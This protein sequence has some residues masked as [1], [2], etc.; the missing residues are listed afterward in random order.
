MDRETEQIEVRLL[1]E[2]IHAKYGYDLRDYSAASM[3]RRVMAA[4]AKAGAPHLGELQH[5]L[6]ADRGFFASVLDDLMVQVSEMF[7]DPPFFR[8]FRSQVVPVLQ[9]Y[10]QLKIWHAGC[11]SGEEVYA[12]AILLSEAGLYD[13]TQIYATDVS[14]QALERAQEGVYPAELA[15]RFADSYRAAGGDGSFDRYVSTAYDRIAVK[16][17]L[18]RNLVFFQ[19]NL[20]SDQALGEMQ[21]IF[22]RNVLI[23][24]GPDLR[25]RVLRKF[26][27]GLCHGGFLCLGMSEQ[28]P[29]LSARRPAVGG[30]ERPAEPPGPDALFVDYASRERIYRKGAPLEAQGDRPMMKRGA[31]P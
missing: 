21:V 17:S 7:R 29:G 24:F 18:R 20:V 15:A 2:A 10:P 30:G 13:R 9:T 6:L 4:L 16:A 14:L 5:R 23:Y 8:A 31:A 3:H 28:L 1:L 27:Q 25:A 19:H 11:A 12:T 26:S 22:C